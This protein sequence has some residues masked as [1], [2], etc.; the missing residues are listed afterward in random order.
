MTYKWNRRC[1]IAG[2]AS[3]AKVY[4]SPEFLGMDRAPG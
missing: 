1:F 2:W 4:P 3:Q